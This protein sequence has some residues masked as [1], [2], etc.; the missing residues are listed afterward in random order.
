[1][2]G[3]SSSWKMHTDIFVLRLFWRKKTMVNIPIQIP[4]GGFSNFV[5]TMLTA[6]PSEGTDSAGGGG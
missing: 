2:G 4:R 1:V 6:L 5:L 3:S